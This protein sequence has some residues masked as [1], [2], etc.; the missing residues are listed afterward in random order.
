MDADTG[1][2]VALGHAVAAAVASIHILFFVL[3]YFNM[4]VFDPCPPFRYPPPVMTRLR[5]RGVVA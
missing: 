1:L 4:W 3:L 5:E 2:A